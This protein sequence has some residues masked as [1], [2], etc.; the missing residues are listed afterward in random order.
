MQ[1]GLL[2]IQLVSDITKIDVILVDILNMVDISVRFTNNTFTASEAKGF[3]LVILE[4]TGGTS[5]S[6]FNVTVTPSEQSPVSAQGN[7]V[8]CMIM[9]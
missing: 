8:M 1:L 3:V 7:S 9:C 6:S 2:L 5:A 4:L